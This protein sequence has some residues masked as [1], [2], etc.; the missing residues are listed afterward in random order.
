[1]QCVWGVLVDPAI[2]AAPSCTTEPPPLAESFG[3]LIEPTAAPPNPHRRLFIASSRNLVKATAVV[4]TDVRGGGPPAASPSAMPPCPLHETLMDLVFYSPWSNSSSPQPAEATTPANS[5]TATSGMISVRCAVRG[6][7]PVR[8]ISSVPPD[9]VALWGDDLLDSGNE[10]I[11]STLVEHCSHIGTLSRG[12]HIDDKSEPP[13]RPGDFPPVDRLPDYEAACSA[14]ASEA[15]AA[16]CPPASTSARS[17]ADPPTST[18]GAAGVRSAASAF[19]TR[20][21]ATGGDAARHRVSMVSSAQFTAEVFTLARFG[22]DGNVSQWLARHTISASLI[23]SSSPTGAAALDGTTGRS[24]RRGDG[25]GPESSASATSEVQPAQEWRYLIKSHVSVAL[26]TRTGSGV[27]ALR[28]RA[29]PGIRVGRPVIDLQAAVTS[30]EA[31][32][33]LDVAVGGGASAAKEH[34]SNIATLTQRM[35]AD[36][37]AAVTGTIVARCGSVCRRG[38]SE[39]LR[40]GAF[41]GGRGGD[42]RKPP[43]LLAPPRSNTPPSLPP[44]KLAHRGAEG[45]QAAATAAARSIPRRDAPNLFLRLKTIPVDI[46]EE[47]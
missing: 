12:D 3:H 18:S 24:K 14:Y 19:V 30:K 21:S 16:C 13:L 7:R 17:A 45:G 1:M 27:A 28:A 22:T 29:L 46:A 44:S 32:D 9:H 43:A 11:T 31:S 34:A 41:L 8:C 36:A 20:L 37:W 25:G 35:E 23:S 15:L 2:L 39:P 47:D 6:G 26:R 33:V 5:S 4:V 40:R 38:L 10:T 42:G